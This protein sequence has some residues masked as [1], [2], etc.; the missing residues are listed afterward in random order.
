MVLAPAPVK[1]SAYQSTNH[2]LYNRLIEAVESHG[3]HD[4]SHDNG[5]NVSQWSDWGEIV[6]YGAL[7]V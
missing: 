1:I 6:N 4:H 5:A 7:L 2:G 3:S